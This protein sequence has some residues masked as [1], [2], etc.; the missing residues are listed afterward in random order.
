MAYLV[1]SSILCRLA[2]FA[3]K[4]YL[5]ADEA[6]TKLHLHGETLHLTAQCL[7]EFRNVATRPKSL[8]GLGLTPFA[9]EA[10]ATLFESVFPLLPETPDIFPAWKA[11]VGPLGVMG[12]QVHGARLVAVCHVHRVTHLLTFNLAHFLRLASVTPGVVVVDP[13]SV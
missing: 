9:A 5:T 8:N 7:V 3:D 11:L 1:D 13:A 6:V 4:L 12:K 2:N 10:K